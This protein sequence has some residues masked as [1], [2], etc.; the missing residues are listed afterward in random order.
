MA[1]RLISVEG[2]IGSG[3]STFLEHLR[4]KYANHPNVVF[5]PEP[6]SIWESIK[7]VGGV[8]ILEKFY[9][10]QETYAFPFQM[11][12]YISRLSILRKLVRERQPDTPLFI[13]TERSLHTDK[14]IFAKMLYDQ[15]KIND[16]NYQIYLKWFHE[17]ADDI[18]VTHCVY[19]KSD[20]DVCYNRVGLRARL[21]EDVI[22]L[23][24]LESCHAYHEE[25]ISMYPDRIVMDANTNLNVNPDVIHTW[26]EQFD[27]IVNQ[28]E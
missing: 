2:N 23:S 20:P 13:I 10:D 25:Y 18:P 24:Y 21:G 26:L 11:M 14:H 27:G 4:V 16:I 7:D 3:K 15:G 6:V 17:F 8:S 22:P 12:A 1:V 5:A 28:K 19:L 9:Q